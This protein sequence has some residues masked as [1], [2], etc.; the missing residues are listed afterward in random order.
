MKA[1]PI[2]GAILYFLIG[3]IAL[4]QSLYY[5]YVHYELLFL[6]WIFFG[7]FL[8]IYGAFL[9]V[10]RYINV[11]R[12]ITA[13]L[14]IIMWINFFNFPIP[15]NVNPLVNYVLLIPITIFLILAAYYTPKEWK[16]YE[17]NTS[18]LLYTTHIFKY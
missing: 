1:D 8:L 14:I 7:I 17:K 5:T 16:K 3:F 13:I 12:L 18:N 4:F 15:S 11:L 6:P 9:L 10:R 2:R